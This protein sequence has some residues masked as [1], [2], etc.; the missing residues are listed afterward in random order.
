MSTAPVPDISPQE[1]LRRER[2]APFRSEYLGGRVVA[3]QGAD[4]VHCR[5]LSN[6]PTTIGNQLR[7]RPCNCYSSALRVSVRGGERY[8]YPD[9]VVTCGEETFEDGE[10]DTLVNPVVIIEVLSPS[11]EAFDRGK[12]FLDY[13]TIPSLQEHVLITPSPRRFEVYRRQG[14]GSWLYQSWAFSPPPL[15]LQSINCTLSADDVYHKVE[16]EPEPD[17]AE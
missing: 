9:L 13:Q 3:R 11:T 6:L 1:Y 8:F 14:D 7:D 12:K 2:L 5:I 4:R 15:V 16:P 17:P 10:M